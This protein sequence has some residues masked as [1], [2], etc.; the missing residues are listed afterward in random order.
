MDEQITTTVPCCITGSQ[1]AV[2][3]AETDRH[4]NPLRTVISTESGLVFSDPRPTPAEIRHF[5]REDYRKKY[6][7]TITPKNKHILRAGRLALRRIQH[8]E[9]HVTPGGSILDAGSGGG[10]FVYMCQ[11]AGYQAVGI[12]PNRGYAT[13]AASQYGI[14]IF[15][16]FYQ[17]A[18]YE[19]A[20]DC[21]TLFHVLEHLEEPV[22]SLSVLAGF[23]KTGGHFFVEVPN[24]D[25]IGTAPHQKWH[26]G[27]LY[28]FNRQTLVA[29]AALAGLRAL[30][31][32]TSRDGGVLMATLEKPAEHYAPDVQQLIEG[33]YLQT[34]KILSGHS[35]LKHYA[36]IHTPLKRLVAK[37]HRGW[38]ERQTVRQC[39]GTKPVDILNGLIDNNVP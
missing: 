17:D 20:F 6:K 27:H 13:F 7:N 37:V 34:H 30:H 10:E 33:S 26:V 19:N 9:N 39:T 35:Q 16:G 5:Y 25:F 18:K 24:V 23:L 8:V 38:N 31:V 4:D 14:D 11:Q 2:V 28:N 1:A 22:S 36:R 3:V 12:E 29:T 21:V 32:E 15:N